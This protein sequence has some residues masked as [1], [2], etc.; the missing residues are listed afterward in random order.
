MKTW[1]LTL[2]AVLPLVA[3]LSTPASAWRA[4]DG[5]YGAYPPA[6]RPY[7]PPQGYYSNGYAGYGYAEPACRQKKIKVYIPDQENNFAPYRYKKKKVTV[8]D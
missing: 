7:A 5:G 1:I 6:Y 3:G 8:C 4:Y 2:A